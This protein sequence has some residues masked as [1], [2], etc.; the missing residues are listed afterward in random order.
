MRPYLPGYLKNKNRKLIFD[1]I[2]DRKQISRTEIS[3]VTDISLPTVSK[4]V[5]KMLEVG[6]VSETNEIEQQEGAG[7][8]GHLM[9]FN[10]DA[11]LT[12][13]IEFEGSIVNIGL[14]NM[15]GQCLER[16]STHID[17]YQK[18][19]DLSRL[20]EFVNE[21]TNIAFS[22]NSK[23]LGIGI[24]F[25]AVINPHNKSIVR[26]PIMNMLEETSFADVFSDFCQSLTLPYY[27]ENDVNLA[28]EGEAFLRRGDECENLL[29]V[30][31]GTGFG[32]GIILNRKLW[33]GMH[34]K[35]GEIGDTLISPASMVDPA[36]PSVAEFENIINLDAIRQKFKIDLQ[37]ERPTE[38]QIQEISDYI[39]PYISLIL[40]NLTNV[41]D[42]N[43]FVVTGIIPQ[44]LGDS[45]LE[46]IRKSLNNAMLVSEQI[47]VV[48][49]LPD[50]CFAG[51]A[52]MVLRNRLDDI[53]DS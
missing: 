25:P 38:S 11:Y 40:F 13:G 39:A 42:I 35:S 15:D 44:I 19:A 17:I 33:R 28:C 31:L 29:Y 10:S 4:A 27:I 51:A 2:R 23:V 5:D 7:R 52:V 53:L 18:N 37:R 45:L 46:R 14:V 21:L 49:A 9:R 26:W 41:L 43:L 6:I 1:L 12:I 50:T 30:S 47:S 34:F 8:K 36:K 24:G 48:P 16:R 3:R 22:M 20:T 32:A